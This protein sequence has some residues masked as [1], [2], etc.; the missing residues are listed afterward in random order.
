M[1][2]NLLIGHTSLTVG[3]AGRQSAGP[4]WKRAETRLLGQ[5]QRAK[6]LVALLAVGA[7]L[8]TIS[9]AISAAEAVRLTVLVETAF[10]AVKLACIGWVLRRRT[11]S[12]EVASGLVALNTACATAGNF[13]YPG[14]F[15][16]FTGQLLLAVLFVTWLLPTRHA[17]GHLVLLAAAAAVTVV[18]V[19]PVDELLRV[20]TLL[21]TG[22]TIAAVSLALRARQA[23]LTAQAT[24][25]PLTGIGNRRAYEERLASALAHA[26]RHGEALSLVVID[27]DGFKQLNDTQGHPAGDAELRTVARL[28]ASRARLQ[29]S[30]FRLGGDEFAVLLPGTGAGGAVTFAEDLSSHAG[31][32][33]IGLRTSLTAGVASFPE[34]ADAPHGLERAADIA[35]LDG[36]RA[37]KGRVLVSRGGEGR[38]PGANH[39]SG[40]PAGGSEAGRRAARGRAL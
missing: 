25:D 7:L 16:P 30:V 26:Q 33:R 28:L 15:R 11:V 1:L 27:L 20:A 10:V 32:R 23:Q 22:A 6:M 19:P 8:S 29:D 4:L 24:L 17:T 14:T 34:H 12:A 40:V 13:L 35:L 36:K 21:L 31:R 37:G 9:V 5:E 38:A 39:D 2:Q 3:A 18:G